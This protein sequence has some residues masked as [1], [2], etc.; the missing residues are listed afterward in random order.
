ML[1]LVVGDRE[2]VITNEDGEGPIVNQSQAVNLINVDRC[3][4]S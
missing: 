2:I 3:I 4:L 1:L